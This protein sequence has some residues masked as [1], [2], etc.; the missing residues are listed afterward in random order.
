MSATDSFRLTGWHVLA[1][2]LLFFGADIAINVGYIV[3]AVHTFPGEVAAEPYEAGI[4]YNKHLAQEAV[5]A[6]LGWV[7]TVDAPAAAANGEAITVLWRDRN[8]QPLT[9]LKVTALL[10]RPATEK[11]NVQ[12]QFVEAEP[13]VYRAIAVAGTGA[14]DMSMTARDAKGAERTAERRLVWR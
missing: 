7:A 3:E 8:G 11:Q 9:G 14:W 2:M 10:T 5:E 6:K 13:G 4:A 1:G 12:I